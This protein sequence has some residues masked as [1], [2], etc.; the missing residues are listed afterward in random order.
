MNSQ[1]SDP[2]TGL[3]YYR[4]RYYDPASGKFLSEDPAA[5]EGDSNF[6][7]YGRNNPVLIADPTGLWPQWP[8]IVQQGW[9]GL[10]DW[11][12]GVVDAG[13]MTLEFAT[14]TGPENRD[15][16]PGSVQVQSLRNSPGVN[17]A[18]QWYCLNGFDSSGQ[19]TPHS[20]GHKFGL[21][22]LFQSGLDPTLQ[23]V[24]SYDWAITPN[25]DGTITFTLTNDTS[26]T[27][28]LYQVGVPSHNRSSFRPF[29]TIRQTYHWTESTPPPCGCKK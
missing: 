1:Q 20:G 10:K 14:G 22:G 19:P 2:E 17:K 11:G 13:Q 29:G 15:F 23:F 16:G 27:S 18:R 25:P 8:P 12:Q 6:F 3:Y 24:G 4:A 9:Q 26:L 21:K 7:R 5:F 28:L